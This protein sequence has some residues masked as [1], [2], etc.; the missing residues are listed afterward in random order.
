DPPF[1]QFHRLAFLQN[2]SLD[3]ALIF[4]DGEPPQCWSIGSLPKHRR[5]R[6]K[7]RRQG[8]NGTDRHLRPSN[9]FPII[10]SNSSSLNTDTPSSFALSS[11]LP[12][13]APA[14]T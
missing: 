8:W 9:H 1:E 10:L 11:L 3:H 6:D 12:A 7:W 4:V 13:S 5:H 2:A 14:I